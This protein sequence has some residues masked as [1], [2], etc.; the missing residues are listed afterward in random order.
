M[1]LEKKIV[2]YISIVVGIVLGVVFL[3]QLSKRLVMEYMNYNQEIKIIPNFLYFE[4]IHNPGAAWGIFAG[5]TFVI[6]IIPFL[7]IIFFTYLLTKGNFSN[8]KIYTI[9]IA[10]ILGGTIGN[11]ID[12]L[13]FG[14]VVDF[15]SF[16]FGSYH[17]P[18]FNIADS[19]LVIGV[20]LFAIDILFLDVKR[21]KKFEESDEL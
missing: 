19:A 20:I 14:Y 2:I 8:K 13:I 9:A 17:Y 11:Y 7:A 6:I 12:R 21:N 1:K 3:D 15:I 10:L 18:N 4:Y 5:N 16:R